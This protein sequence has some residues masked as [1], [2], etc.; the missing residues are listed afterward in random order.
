MTTA[1][2]LNIIVAGISAIATALAVFAAFRSAKSAEE[3][4][5]ALI[6]SQLSAGR[7][8]VAQL[9]TGCAAEYRRVKFQALTLKVLNRDLAFYSGA[10]GGS[11]HARTEASVA[12][13]LEAAEVSFRPA[14]AFS[15]D[16]AAVSRLVPEDVDRLCVDLT[17]RLGELQSIGDELTRE[18]RSR[19]DQVLQHRAQGLAAHPKP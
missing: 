7:R 9:V 5:R 3:A 12:K 8:E 4:Q 19:E 10:I 16:P 15:G 18:S 14:A 6:D 13:M 1:E 11:A 17:M 2:N